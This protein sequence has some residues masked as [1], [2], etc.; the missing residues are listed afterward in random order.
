M[1]TPSRKTPE[2]TAIGQE[3]ISTA[4]VR[5]RI[6]GRFQGNWHHVGCERRRETCSGEGEDCVSRCWPSKSRS[7]LHL[8]I[9]FLRRTEVKDAK[10]TD[11]RGQSRHFRVLLITVDNTSL[12]SSHV[13]VYVFVM[14]AG[15][16][17]EKSRSNLKRRHLNRPEIRGGN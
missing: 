13:Y 4:T 11:M 6:Q 12:Q 9:C 8:P 5:V 2:G 15:L 16:P 3:G 14:L 1:M 7:T 10:Y 17:G